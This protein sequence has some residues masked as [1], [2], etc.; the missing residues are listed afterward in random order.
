MFLKVV[1]FDHHIWSN[2]NEDGE[3]LTFYWNI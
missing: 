2:G 1:Y 3:L